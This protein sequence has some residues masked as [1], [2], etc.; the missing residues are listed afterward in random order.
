VGRYVSELRLTDQQRH[1]VR[2]RAEELAERLH[3]TEL[4]VGKNPRGVA[5]ACIYHAGRERHLGV[6]QEELSDVAEVTPIT[7]RSGWRA[8]QWMEGEAA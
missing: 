5:A 1:R 3:E 2:H 8:V 7:L 6:T 4:S